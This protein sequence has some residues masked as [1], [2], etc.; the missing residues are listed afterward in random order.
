MHLCLVLGHTSTKALSKLSSFPVFSSFHLQPLSHLPSLLRLLIFPPSLDAFFYFFRLPPCIS[1]PPLLVTSITKASI[2]KTSII[3]SLFISPSVPAS[4]FFHLLHTPALLCFSASQK[5]FNLAALHFAVLFRNTKRLGTNTVSYVQ[6][7]QPGL[8]DTRRSH[9]AFHVKLPLAYPWSFARP[10]QA[11][12]P[13][14]ITSYHVQTYARFHRR[15]PLNPAQ[16][17]FICRKSNEW[18]SVQST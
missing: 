8:R 12:A 5:H 2:I 17:F 3:L 13:L 7:C 14:R 1:L 4:T 16:T 10:S 15:I 6:R 18:L 11:A 9:Q